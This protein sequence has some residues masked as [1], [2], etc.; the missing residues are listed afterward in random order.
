MGVVT[1]FG[2][3]WIWLG[4]AL[5]LGVAASVWLRRRSYRR[6]DDEI[7]RPVSPC[8][9]AVLIVAGTAV[10]LPLTGSRPAVVQASYLIGLVWG[11]LLTL[12]DLDVRRLPDLLVLPAYPV[13][14]LLLATCSLVTGSWSA[15]LVALGCAGAA[16][17]VFFLAAMVSPSADGLGLGDVKLAGVLG[18]LLGWLSW[19]NAVMGLL[20][21]FVVGGLAGAVLLIL[22]R[23]NRRSHIAFGPAMLVGAY[24][25]CV[26]PPL[27]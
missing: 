13:V 21:G 5:V 9:A 11:V 3:A 22:G 24:V 15:L 18:A 17:A 2:G 12:I 7:Y 4:V 6:P 16:V 23:A 20:S 26:L 8:W 14:V 25:W 10:A 19:L 1:P 27:S